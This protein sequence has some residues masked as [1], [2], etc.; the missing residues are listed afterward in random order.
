M[1]ART[2]SRRP[3]LA[4]TASAVSC[5]LDPSC[6][7]SIQVREGS[8]PG[9]TP[10]WVEATAARA[11]VT[12]RPRPRQSWNTR[13]PSS[14]RSRSCTRFPTQAASDSASSTSS[15]ATRDEA[16]TAVCSSLLRLCLMRWPVRVH[17]VPCS[18]CSATGMRGTGWATAAD[19]D[20]AVSAPD[21]DGGAA[22]AAAAAAAAPGPPAEDAA[23]AAVLAAAAAVAT[24]RTTSI[25]PCCTPKERFHP[26]P[27]MAALGKHSMT[28]R[29]RRRTRCRSRSA[30]TKTT[31]GSMPSP[32]SLDRPVGRIWRNGSTSSRRSHSRSR[33]A[34]MWVGPARRRCPREG[35]PPAAAA[36]AA[37]R[38]AAAVA[39]S[40]S[41][42]DHV[43]LASPRC[44]WSLSIAPAKGACQQST[45]TT[46]GCSPRERRCST[47]NFVDRPRP[48][49]R[50]STVT[51]PDSARFADAA[52]ASRSW[53]STSACTAL[54]SGPCFSLDSACSTAR[55]TADAAGPGR[56]SGK[57]CCTQPDGSRG[58]AVACAGCTS[59][60][61]TDPADGD[62]CGMLVRVAEAP[63]AGRARL[64]AGTASKLPSA[65]PRFATSGACGRSVQRRP[66]CRP[67]NT[68]DRSSPTSFPHPCGRDADHQR[69]ALVRGLKK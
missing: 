39:A 36:A 5:R 43:A 13:G 67:T 53:A 2:E 16:S 35:A 8:S 24:P 32:R 66:E 14:R 42:S 1:S 18:T 60:S 4:A 10:P 34:R 46:V 17:A 69:L 57:P 47:M 15:A 6:E 58:S 63:T 41:Q 33:N 22:A 20:P 48:A 54:N 21:A 50:S 49:P 68:S 26:P 31:S 65:R 19:S 44:P 25:T 7:Q 59:G 40:G 28:A 51:R 55:A 37:G 23:A 12:L 64:P 3:F 56:S 62:D 27:Q 30:S 61:L 29:S 52:A 11:A 45:A 38:S 9:S